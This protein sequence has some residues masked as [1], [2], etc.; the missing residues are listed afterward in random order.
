MEGG[1]LGLKSG[2]LLILLMDF[3]QSALLYLTILAFV[4][5]YCLLYSIKVTIEYGIQQLFALPVLVFFSSDTSKAVAVR[6]RRQGGHPSDTESSC[7]E[8]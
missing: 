4:N 3:S 5:Q 7:L 6:T 2:Q 1:S 8:R